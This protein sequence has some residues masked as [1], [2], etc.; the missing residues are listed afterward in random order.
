[1]SRTAH[2]PYRVWLYRR[3]RDVRFDGRWHLVHLDLDPRVEQTETKERLGR[4]FEQLTAAD[5][6]NRWDRQESQLL[7]SDTPDGVE[8]TAANSFWWAPD[9]QEVR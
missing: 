7:L 8:V 2:R 1:M 6:S 9:P 3:Y 4:L 5:G